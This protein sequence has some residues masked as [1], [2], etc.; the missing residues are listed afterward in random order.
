[1]VLYYFFENWYVIGLI[2]FVISYGW[3][4]IDLMWFFFKCY[5]EKDGWLLVIFGVV[6]FF[7]GVEERILCG[8]EEKYSLFNIRDF[9]FEFYFIVEFN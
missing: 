4:V 9:S 2:F 7:F 3:K 5:F 1:M 8:R 6:W